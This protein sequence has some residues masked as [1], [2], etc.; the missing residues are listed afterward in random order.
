MCETVPATGAEHSLKSQ[1]IN[2]CSFL[3]SPIRE[4]ERGRDREEERMRGMER[5]REKERK[6]REGGRKREGERE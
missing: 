1:R 2:T 4:G 3:F 6:N 5:G